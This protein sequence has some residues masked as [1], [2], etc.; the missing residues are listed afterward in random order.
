MM[1]TGN[2]G[3]CR[4][5]RQSRWYEI[6][7]P[8][9]KVR[10]SDYGATLVSLWVKEAQTDVVLGFDQVSGYE[11]VRYMGAMVGRVANRIRGARFTLDQQEYVLMA[12]DHGN[13]LHGGQIGLDTQIWTVSHHEEQALTLTLISPQGQDHFPGTLRIEVTYEL[14]ERQLRIHSRAQTDQATPVSLTNHAYFCLAQGQPTLQGHQLQIASE[15]IGLLDEQGC[16]QHQTMEVADTPFDF[17]SLCS[18]TA[19]L[20]QD[21]PQL[22][23]GG[24]LDHNFV[25]QGSGWK[26]AAQLQCGALTM[27]VMTDMPDMHVYTANFLDG[28]VGRNGDRYDA[29]CAIC[30]ETQFYP[31]DVH[32]AYPQSI[33]RPG[34]VY[35]HV[36][37]FEFEYHKTGERK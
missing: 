13:T 36:T 26:Q 10:I 2:F 33:L 34:E 23:V 28:A 7:N 15:R 16:T 29:Q 1:R 14:K 24:G 21:H 32:R 4:D 12:N 25:L 17:R 20:R 31:D 35:D 37:A 18:V 19:C 11:S 22:R 30:F 5:G 27:R 9:L 3:Q 8:W 6:E